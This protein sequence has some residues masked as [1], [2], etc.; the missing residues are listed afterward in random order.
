[1]DWKLTREMG[2]NQEHAVAQLAAS[3]VGYANTSIGHELPSIERLEVIAMNAKRFILAGRVV[4]WMMALCTAVPDLRRASIHLGSTPDVGEDGQIRYDFDVGT[5]CVNS[6]SQCLRHHAEVEDL[7]VQWILEDGTYP[8]FV[9]EL[10]A[11]DPREEVVLQL[12][13]CRDSLPWDSRDTQ[14]RVAEYF[15]AFREASPG[16]AHEIDVGLRF[17]ADLSSVEER[18]PAQPRPRAA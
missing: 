8:T 15:R 4:D 2:T 14:N 6:T 18:Q 9:R 5:S 7:A 11:A 12:D 13:L 17:G 10:L 1:M 3:L 16:V